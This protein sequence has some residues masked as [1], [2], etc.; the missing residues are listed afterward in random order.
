MR[1]ESGERNGRVYLVLEDNDSG[2]DVREF[3]HGTKTP[4]C[5]IGLRAMRE[6][7][8]AFNGEFDLTSGSGGTCVEIT[9]PVAE[10]R[11]R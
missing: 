2:F 9:L 5:G 1:L 6:E 7:V 3:L 8:L 10:N 4:N 11:E